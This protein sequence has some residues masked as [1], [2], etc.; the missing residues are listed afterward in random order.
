ML[1]IAASRSNEGPL[2]TVRDSGGGISPEILPEIFN[3]LFTTKAKG[4]GLGLA[5]VKRMLEAQ[6]GDIEI[7]SEVGIGTTAAIRVRRRI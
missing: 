3:P 1:A 2:L 6:G 7:D 5:V 4:M